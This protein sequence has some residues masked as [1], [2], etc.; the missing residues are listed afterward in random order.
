MSDLKLQLLHVE[1][2]LTDRYVQ[3]CVHEFAWS[4]RSEVKGHEVRDSAAVMGYLDGRRRI[5]ASKY[6]ENKDLTV[7]EY[8]FF[9]LSISKRFVMVLSQVHYKGSVIRRLICQSETPSYILI[10]SRMKRH[11]ADPFTKGIRPGLKKGDRRKNALR[12]ELAFIADGLVKNMGGE[13]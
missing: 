12:K 3:L 6:H 10:G 4:Q 9:P 7:W 13:W 11:C 8:D 1:A 2:S 5:L